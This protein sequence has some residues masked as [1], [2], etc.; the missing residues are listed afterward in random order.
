MQVYKEIPVITNQARVRP[1]E[2]VGIVSVTE[3]WTVAR[4][5]ARAEEVIDADAPEHF[6]LDAGTGMY[7]NAILLNIPLAP[8]VSQE[9]RRRAQET[10]EDELN[11]RRAAR[12]R[13]LELAG[14][15]GRGSIWDGDLRYDTA[16]VYLRP[17]R[18]AIDAAID[19]R[20]RKIALD[21][22]Q[23]AAE[24]KALAAVNPSVTDS[25]GVRELTEHL[26][27]TLSLQQ[28]EELIATRTRRLARRQMRWFDKL[29]RTLDG[30]ARI[31]L[32]R[33]PDHHK[34]VHSM[35]GIL[36]I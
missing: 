11:P 27:G 8:K 33:N 14:A 22:L 16:I 36:R 13:E 30:R 34:L 26:S 1:A 35:H 28:A 2:L 20:S 23:E 32:V 15:E 9:L 6:V 12:A 10:V 17:D 4:H 3:E 19:E 31:T 29:A 24:I 25:V 7:L 5:K 18:A 21:G